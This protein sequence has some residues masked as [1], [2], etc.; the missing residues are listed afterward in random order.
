MSVDYIVEHPCD[1]KRHFGDGDPEVGTMGLLDMLKARDRARVFREAAA[2]QGDDAGDSTMTIITVLPDGQSVEQVVSVADLEKEAARLMNWEKTCADCPANAPGRPFGCIGV[3]NYPI[4]AEDENWLLDQ[5]QPYRTIGNDALLGI[6]KASRVKGR[7][8]AA[9]RSQGMCE[10][11]EGRD[12]VFKRGIF[13][14]LSVT[15]DQMIQY[16]LFRSNR[17]AEGICL[18]I[19]LWF[20][21]VQIDGRIPASMDDAGYFTE[22]LQMDDPHERQARTV[23]VLPRPRFRHAPPAFFEYLHFLYTAWSLGTTI[24]IDA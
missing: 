11:A 6:M 1:V 2:Q 20:G 21:A 15:A 5:L 9:M 22:L 16:L 3:M 17:L 18:M 7:D 19:P 13:R 14:R 12:V 23:F 8:V 10:L 4:P 24:W